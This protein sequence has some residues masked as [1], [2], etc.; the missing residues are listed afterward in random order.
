[1]C[2]E[3]GVCFSNCHVHAPRRVGGH[4]SRL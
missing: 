4:E 2:V 3:G 1:V